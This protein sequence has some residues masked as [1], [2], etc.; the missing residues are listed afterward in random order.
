MYTESRA[1][2]SRIE[3]SA[4][5]RIARVYFLRE[6]MKIP[7]KLGMSREHWFRFPL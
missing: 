4:R 7:G 2:P 5:I 1:F 6:I 3:F